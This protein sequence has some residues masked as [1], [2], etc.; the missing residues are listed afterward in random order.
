MTKPKHL[1]SATR[2]PQILN[3]DIE[4]RLQQAK[5]AL[6]I[7]VDPKYTASKAARQYK[8]PYNTLRN[9][10]KGIQ[11]R[12]KAHEKEMLLS[13]GE[14]KAVV[15]WIRFLGLAGIPIC[16]RTLRPKVKA[17]MA[18]KG[19]T[20]RGSGLD[21]KRAQAFNY[22]TVNEYFEDLN[23]VLT[24]N[25]IPWEHV[26]NM[27]EKGV[28]MGGGRKNSQ[29]RYFFSRNDIKMYRQHSDDLQLVTIIDSVC[30]DGTAPITPAF[31]FPGTKM[32]KEWMQVDEDIMIA[33]SENGW[34]DNEIGFQWFKR[35]FVPQATA[36]REANGTSDKPILLIYNGH[37]SHTTLDWVNLALE[38]NIILLCL[39]SHTTHRLQPLDVG[40]FGPLQSAWF[41]RCDEVL[42]LTGESM[43]L[44]NVVKEYWECR[45]LAFKDTTISQAWRKSGINP[46]NPSVF[47]DADFAP[48]IPSSTKAH[49]PD[50]FPSRLP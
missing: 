1:R 24:K 11:P 5:E 19:L 40:C 17:I 31:V 25:S 2:K 45:K 28:Q 44:R 41:N 46:F 35:C 3:K 50:S 9:R 18:A 32:H 13:G 6:F 16:K 23:Q 12:E 4:K 22:T 33:T 27:D 43:D 7:S 15:D 48:S 8:V 47:T 37:A 39:P 38:N 20:A 42:E 49:L 26:Y 29:R 10:L 21:P 34:T 14:K 36:R 30:A